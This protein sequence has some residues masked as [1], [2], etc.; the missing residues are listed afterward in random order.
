MKVNHKYLAKLY[1]FSN[2]N[3]AGLQGAF[4]LD[5]LNNQFKKFAVILQLKMN[6]GWTKNIR[7]HIKSDGSTEKLIGA[8]KLSAWNT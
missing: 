8:I 1:T 5:Q 2:M 3:L 7:D 6:W 4:Q